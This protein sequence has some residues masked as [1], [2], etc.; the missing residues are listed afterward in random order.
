ML[1]SDKNNMLAQHKTHQQLQEEDPE[2]QRAALWKY[3][4]DGNKVLLREEIDG[5]TFP[6]E[7]EEEDLM[8]GVQKLTHGMKA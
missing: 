4:E 8:A 1:K 3:D 6:E 2:Y 5:H 7:E